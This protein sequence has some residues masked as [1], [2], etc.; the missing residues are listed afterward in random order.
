MPTMMIWTTCKI[1]AT[2]KSP[3]A[4]GAPRCLPN[5]KSLQHRHPKNPT[6]PQ[7]RHR[8]AGPGISPKPQSPT[9]LRRRPILPLLHKPRSRK[10]TQPALL[11]RL[12]L[13]IRVLE[14]ARRRANEDFGGGGRAAVEGAGG[15]ESDGCGEGGEGAGGYGRHG[16]L[17]VGVGD[18][19]LGDDSVGGCHLRRWAALRYVLFLLRSV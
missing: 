15:G 8:H 9:R 14:Q 3:Q 7:H 12:A 10:I 16:V 19:W 17:V 13:A 11:R 5:S 4:F 1:N 2:A 18:W 6:N